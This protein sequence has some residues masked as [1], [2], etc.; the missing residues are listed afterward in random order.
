MKTPIVTD[1][2][3]R[4]LAVPITV[5]ST[6]GSEGRALAAARKLR[7]KRPDDWVLIVA[8]PETHMSLAC[9]LVAIVDKTR[10]AV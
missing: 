4:G 7:A 1:D 5:I 6:H 9:W 3:L 2:V 10:Y 8:Q